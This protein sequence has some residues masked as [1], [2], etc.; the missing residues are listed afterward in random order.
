M[1]A[2]PCEIDTTRL[3]RYL[4]AKLA[5]FRGPLAVDRL[6]GGQS[7][8][9]YR[10][11]AASG[12]YV[13]RSQPP[14]TLLRSAHAVDREFRVLR[15]L[16]GTRFPAPRPHCLCEDVSVIGAMFY[17]MTDVEGRIFW[18]TALPDLG[19][20]DRARAYGDM[21]RAMAE[22]HSLDVD[23]IGLRGYGKPGNYFGRQFERWVRQYRN[24]ETAPCAAME[25]T[26]DWLGRHLP[27]DDGEARLVHGDYRL[28]NII[29]HATEARAVAVIDWELS[30]LGHPFADLSYFCAA[31]RLPR[32]GPIKSL[33]GLD[34]AELGI[35]EEAQIIEQYCELRG[36]DRVE[37]WT[38]YLAFS[39]FRLAAILQGVLRRALDG[40]ASGRHATEVGLMA[41]EVATLASELIEAGG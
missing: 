15:A 13:L 20:D 38:F 22:L 29:F 40:N 34:R 14:G 21:V 33:Q 2:Y 28:D 12:S 31:L 16:A 17:I 1:S 30:T 18:D 10:L 32:K 39:L 35:P 23:A 11:R 24:A 8:P 9:T 41:G 36:I 25:A 4:Q 6:P 37:H 5:G 3:S 27:A 26:I 7:N 19:R